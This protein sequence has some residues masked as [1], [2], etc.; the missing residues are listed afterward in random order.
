MLIIAHLPIR[1]KGVR[2][3]EK[4]QR[5]IDQYVVKFHEHFI[6]L[7][8]PTQTFA[9]SSLFTRGSY[10]KEVHS[11]PSYTITT[12]RTDFAARHGGISFMTSMSANFTDKITFTWNVMT[13]ESDVLLWNSDFATR[14][15][16]PF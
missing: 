15:L 3:K 9:I 13:Y 16:S 1:S 5:K 10:K 4:K 2:L 12:I 11:R 6:F 8:T 14:L 7:V